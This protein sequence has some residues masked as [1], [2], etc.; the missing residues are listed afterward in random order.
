MDSKERVIKA[1]NLEVPDRIPFGEFAID[2]D[3]VEKIIGHETYLRAKAKCRIALWEGRRDEVAQSWKEDIV[4][5]YTKLDCIDIV[6]IGCM[7]SGLLPEKSYNPEPPKRVDDK[8]W[9]DKKGSI[10]KLS[11]ITHDITMVYDPNVWDEE[12]IEEDFPADICIKPPDESM[13]EVVDYVIE[14][15]GDKKFVLGTAGEEVGLVLLGGME[16]GLTEYISN[17]VTV[18]A[19]YRH[20][21]NAANE[22]DKYYIRCRTDGILWGQDF[23]YKSGPMISPKMYREFVLPFQEERVKNV[24]KHGVHVLKHACGNNW[25]L[26][27]MFIEAGFECYQS[28]QP[29]A[30]MDIKLVKEKYGNRIC[31]WGGVSVEHLI[32]GTKEDIKRDVRYAI[33]NAAQ[34]GG[35]IFGSSHSIAVGSNYDN[36]MTML[37]EFDKLA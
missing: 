35:Y 33:E 18:K 6:N 32:S 9:M 8:T 10:Y 12:Y 36:F 20:Y 22:L 3:T 29:T 25:N 2:F 7:A 11:K 5:L 16:R 15:L 31:L 21:V 19:A 4:E 1:L 30:D 34:G 24:K 13:F 17:P 23:A 28:I 26:L 37:N 27:D 14:K